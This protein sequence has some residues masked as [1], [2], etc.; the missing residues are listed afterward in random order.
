MTN[1]PS[2]GFTLLPWVWFSGGQAE[3]TQ[4]LDLV[5]GN[6]NLLSCLSLGCV[7]VWS[8]GA[9]KELGRSLGGV[10]KDFGRILE[11]TWEEFGRNLERFLEGSWKDFGG[12]LD[13][14]WKE[15]GGIL[16][17]VWRALGRSWCQHG[18]PRVCRAQLPFPARGPSEILAESWPSFGVLGVAEPS[19]ECAWS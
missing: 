16:G 19:L 10:W 2:G 5:P 11:E 17:G 6:P 4:G 12:I 3:K 13:G 1:I 9:W 8:K 7:W 18:A 15:F 14:I